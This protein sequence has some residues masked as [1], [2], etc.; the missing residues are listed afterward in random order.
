MKLA[1]IGR[2]IIFTVYI[3]FNAIFG[4]TYYVI[5]YFNL[6]TRPISRQISNIQTTNKDIFEVGLD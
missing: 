2:K 4:V 1:T 3:Y 6:H 5:W